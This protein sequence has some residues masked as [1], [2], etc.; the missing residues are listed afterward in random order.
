MIKAYAAPEQGK[1]FEEIEYDPGDLGP[2][3]VEVA[4]EYCGICHSDLSMLDNDWGMSQYPFVGGHEGVGKV[5]AIGSHVPE[6]KVKVGDR[7]GVGWSS[8]SCMHCDQCMRGNQVLCPTA[9][10]TIVGR[11]GAFADKVRCHWAW[12]INIPEGVDPAS[13]GPLFCGG[14]TVFNPIVQHALPG[15]ARVG[16][17]GIGGLGHMALMFLNKWGCE[18]TAISRGQ[19]K[20]E[21][22]RELGAHHFVAT[23]E[24]GALDKL[25][26]RFDMILNTTNA[27]LPWDAYVNALKPEG[28]LHTVG[29]VMGQFGTSNAFPLIMGRK[30]LS[31][32]PT[33]SPAT[34]DD[35]LAF[36]ARHQI[37]PMTETYAM[38]NIND[39]FEKLRSGSPRYRLVLKNG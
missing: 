21:E 12:A 24:D 3:D 34:M 9:E 11:H 27:D 28:V 18:V 8:A 37:T 39:A 4:V 20:E 31:G 7:V 36:C 30:S 6:G 25:A 17:I 38:S 23:S 13:A 26:G 1:P 14:I 5:V 16:V 10:A 19:D 29:A 22:A 35:M 15:T 32:S 2:D 33:G